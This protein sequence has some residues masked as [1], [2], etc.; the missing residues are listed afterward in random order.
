VRAADRQRIGAALSR[1]LR[2]KLPAFLWP[3]AK[4]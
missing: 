3:T 4:E 2:H 1:R